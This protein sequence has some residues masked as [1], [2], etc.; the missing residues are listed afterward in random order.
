LRKGRTIPDTFGRV[1]LATKN[2]RWYATFEAHRSVVPQAQTGRSVGLDRGIRALVATSDEKLID[3]PRYVDASR[4]KVE[5]HARS[6]DAVTQKDAAGRCLNKRDPVRKAAARRLARAKEHEANCRRDAAHKLSREIVDTYDFIALEDLRLTSMTRSA[7][8][9]VAEP[10][11]NVRAKSGL[12]RALLDAGLGQ[13][14]T[15]IREKA[16]HA[17]RTVIGV[18]ARYSSQTC[19]VCG[20][21]AKENRDGPRFHCGRCGHQADADINA[22]KIILQ[23]AQLA[24]TRAP[25][26]ARVRQHDAA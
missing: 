11:S 13:L 15:L 18:N 12:N 2:G 10:G 8:G 3:N 17:A 1:F 22:A 4:L 25:G 23:R 16:A 26:T 5:L 14:A 21:V 7:K 6:L 24:P 20:H 19:A 9:T